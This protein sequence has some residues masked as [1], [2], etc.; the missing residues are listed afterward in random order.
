MDSETSEII[1]KGKIWL[2]DV[3]SVAGTP[4]SSYVA[5]EE[6][7]ANLALILAQKLRLQLINDLQNLSLN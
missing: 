1:K 4:Y 7:S 2:V 6:T 5:E 3:Y